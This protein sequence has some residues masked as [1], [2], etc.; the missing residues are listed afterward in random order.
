[1]VNE[2]LIVAGFGGQGVLMIGKMVAI[3]GMENG[4]E[5]S[6]LPSYGS[7]M[8]GGT[9]SCSVNLS[10]DPVDSPTILKPTALI[11]LNLP[12]L[13]KYE[14]WA[15]PGARMLLNSSLVEEEPTRTDIRVYKIPFNELATRA[16]NERAMN[17]LVTGAYAAITGYITLENLCD[18]IDHTFV[19]SKAKYAEGNRKMAELGYKYAKE[20]FPE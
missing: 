19:D 6:W 10:T 5:V 8:R 4:L 9:A 16:G 17:M 11:I 13:L 18:A 2:K 14:S 1:M 3:S 7:E 12:S 20:H 15:V